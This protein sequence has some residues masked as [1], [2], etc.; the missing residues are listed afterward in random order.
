MPS[1]SPFV[2]MDHAATTA[3]DPRVLEAMRPY[4]NEEYGNASS[5]HRLGTEARGAVESAR[6]RVAGILNAKPAEIIFTSCGT[7]SDNLALRGV[8]H[9]RPGKHIITTPMEHHAV[10]HTCQQLAEAFG[11]SITY[12]PVDAHGA[13]DPADV[14]RAIAEDTCLISVM[15]ANNEVGTIEPIARIGEIARK[16]G[17]PFHTDAVQAAG[18]LNLDVDALGVDLLSLSGH[19][20]Y[21]PK[22][23]GVLYVREGTDLLPTQTGGD[24]EQGRRAGTENVPYIVG[25]ARA[26]ELAH[27]DMEDNVAHVTS[28]RDR[29][30]EGVLDGIPDVRLTGHPTRRLA[31]N[32]SFVF[33]GVEGESVVVHLD[34]VG[35][36]ASTGSACTSEEEGPS[37]VLS[38]MGIRDRLAQSSLRLSLGRENTEDDVDYVLA[39]LPD[40]VE[41]LRE[42]SPFYD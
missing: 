3:V 7:E 26:L 38:A 36:A 23:V 4:F 18:N 1:E 22:G 41:N 10:G 11:F 33:E 8:G 28:L 34:R 2:Y 19:K 27:E 32:A 39:V 5:V 6:A 30:I 31:N 9:A 17:V 14:E 24:H 29:L 37:F 20:F 16:R 12:L 35:V 15:Y 42:L 21:A 25:L 13:I 40:I